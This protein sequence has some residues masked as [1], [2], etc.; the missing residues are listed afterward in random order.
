MHSRKR[1]SV[2]KAL[3]RK[4]FRTAMTAVTLLLAVLLVGVNVATAYAT[5]AEAHRILAQLVDREKVLSALGDAA[6]AVASMLGGR[7]RAERYAVFSA[8]PGDAKRGMPSYF[9][10]SFYGLGKDLRIDAQTLEGMDQSEAEKLLHH[11]FSQGENA[12]IEGRFGRF[13]YAGTKPDAQGKRQVVFLDLSQ[14]LSREKALLQASIFF[15]MLCL[16]AMAGIVRL[17]SVRAARPVA[18]SIEAQSRFVADAGHEM[19]TP[20]SIILANLDAMELFS[21]PNKYSANIRRQAERMANLTRRLMHLAS[22]ATQA[23]QE[24]ILFDIREMME[25]VVLAYEPK[26]AERGLSYRE[27]LQGEEMVADAFAFSEIAHIL[28][29]NAVTYAALHTE[30]LCEGRWSGRAYA[31]SLENAVDAVP[32]VPPETLFDRFYRADPS[33]KTETGNFGMG[34]SIARAMAEAAGGDIRCEYGHAAL[35]F[36]VTLPAHHP[37]QEHT[38]K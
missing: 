31:L 7:S 28:M 35:R 11:V 2:E 21:P 8:K 6:P 38:R 1:P 10:A 26:L 32:D 5:R 18:R 13:Y 37:A 16:V 27:T 22:A 14:Q 25:E 17:F 15:G 29:E 33:R 19:K 30:I 36:T 24:P 23:P 3:A 4:F 34:L 20:V 9:V 12:P